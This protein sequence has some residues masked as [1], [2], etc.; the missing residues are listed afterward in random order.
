MTLTT[1][2][3][4]AAGLGWDGMPVDVYDVGTGKL[5]ARLGHGRED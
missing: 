1:T 4:Y 5:L 2:R 3:L